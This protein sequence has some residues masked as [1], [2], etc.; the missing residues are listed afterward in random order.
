M[1]Q[2]YS[3]FNL[4]QHRETILKA[5]QESC[6]AKMDILFLGSLKLELLI[7]NRN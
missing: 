2:P 4:E 6:L 1:Y 3:V 5:I 7:D